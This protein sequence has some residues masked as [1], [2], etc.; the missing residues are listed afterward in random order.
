MD[1]AEKNY[2]LLEAIAK[3]LKVQ[4]FADKLKLA[5]MDWMTY[6]QRRANEIKRIMMELAPALEKAAAAVPA[7]KRKGRK[8]VLDLRQRLTILVAKHLL[9]SSSRE[10]SYN[11]VL[12]SAVNGRL[13]SYRTL[14]RMY[15]EKDV[16]IALAELWE[17][18]RSGK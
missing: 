11:L 4:F 12:L 14:E 6:H 8:P 2:A 10:M 9:G 16:G 7:A 1:L 18:V 5:S 3:Q 13:F 15:G 17:I